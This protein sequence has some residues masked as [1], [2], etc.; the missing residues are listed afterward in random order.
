MG[1][2]MKSLKN[3][4]SLIIAL[5]T[6][7]L[8][9]QIFI[10]VDRTIDAYENNLNENYSIIVVSDQNISTEQ[11]RLINPIINLG[12]EISAKAIIKRIQNEMKNKKIDLHKIVLP[13]FYRLHL[14]SFPTP[15]EINQ[16]SDQ[17]QR[18]S[19]IKRVENFSQTHNTTYKLLLL[20]K[21]VT[22]ILAGA[23]LAV[24]TLLILKEMR[25]WQFQHRERMNIMALFGAPVWLRSAV[26]FRLSI[27][28]ALI[29]TFLAISTFIAVEHY[30][31]AQEALRVI[32][33]QIP[34]FN[35]FN[36]GLILLGVALSLSIILASLI[37][38]G[39]KEE[40]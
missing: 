29:A 39:H 27:V 24:T 6:I 26:L 33:V 15:T 7:L 36:D 21:W 4:L 25:I 8:T 16:L 12:E 23:I 9:L 19:Y 18:K 11:F 32:N 40:V 10:G 20:F 34:L 38:M 31:W 37:V 22:M 17:L 35:T 1:V 2:F 5:F 13:H 3:H 14:D 28:D 30:G